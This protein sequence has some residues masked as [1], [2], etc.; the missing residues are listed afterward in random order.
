MSYYTTQK[1]AIFD[2][3]LGVK[4]HPTAEE[5]YQGV[6][7]KMPNIGVATVYR[8]LDKLA[9]EGKIR[10]LDIGE[11]K[12]RYDADISSHQHFI[13]TSCGRV[14]DMYL[15]DLLNVAKIVKKVQCHEVEDYT[16]ELRGTCAKCK[17][18]NF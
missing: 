4:T 14:T 11:N 16:L 8:N 3:L 5:V 10:E 13:C 15:S 1:Q 17:N 18:P 12:K 7:Q 6:K 9:K 2:W